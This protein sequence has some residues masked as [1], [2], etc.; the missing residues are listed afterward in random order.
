MSTI[1]AMPYPPEF[2]GLVAEVTET[3]MRAVCQ[4]SP[5][6]YV[7]SRMIAERHALIRMRRALP[8]RERFNPVRAY[9]F[10]RDIR[11]AKTVR[12]LALSLLEGYR[13]LTDDLGPRSCAVASGPVVTVAGVFP[14]GRAMV[15]ERPARSFD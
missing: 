1:P 3:A 7:T 5:V 6:D 11:R 13:R 4:A 9:A 2:T 14:T 12:T 15:A 8:P 10:R